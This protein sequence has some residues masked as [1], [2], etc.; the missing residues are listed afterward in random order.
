MHAIANGSAQ[1]SFELSW[2]Y[3]DRKA[4]FE[5]GP[6]FKV[7]EYWPRPKEG[8]GF[9]SRTVIGWLRWGLEGKKSS[10]DQKSQQSLI[11]FI[12]WL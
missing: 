4:Y 2:W 10:P 11:P 6:D 1:C 3:D 5:T 8:W 12:P 9:S 7:L